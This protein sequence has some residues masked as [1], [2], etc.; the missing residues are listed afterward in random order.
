M[1]A[2]PRFDG[3]TK[4]KKKKAKTKTPFSIHQ[5]RSEVDP[6][7]VEVSRSESRSSGST[8]LSTSSISLTD[9]RSPPASVRQLAEFPEPDE[10]VLTRLIPIPGRSL[11]L[12]VLPDGRQLIP[13]SCLLRWCQRSIMVSTY[14]HGRGWGMLVLVEPERSIVRLSFSG[15]WSFAGNAGF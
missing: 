6:R 15:L 14:K 9:Q 1:Q 13:L 7:C 5:M 8:L 10:Q 2:L 3:S 12:V 11:C 4:K